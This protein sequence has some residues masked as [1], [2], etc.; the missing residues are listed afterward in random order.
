LTNG[1]GETNFGLNEISLLC[2]QAQNSDSKINIMYLISQY[3]VLI[4]YSFKSAID[5]CASILDRDNENLIKKEEELQSPAQKKNE[6]YLLSLTDNCTAKI[7][8]AVQAI[9]IYKQFRTK[10]VAPRCKLRIPLEITNAIKIEVMI[11][12]KTSE[13][14]FQSL[15]KYSTVAP[16]SR[17]LSF[18]FCLNI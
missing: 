9:E 7:F 4:K 8:S 5:F 10:S 17:N 1:A 15:K 11:F 14:K 12:G 18:Y 16:F 2:K 6:E 3:F 13:Q